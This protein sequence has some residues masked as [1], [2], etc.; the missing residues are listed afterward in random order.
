MSRSPEGYGRGA[1]GLIHLATKGVEKT[2]NDLSLSHD[3][4][5]TSMQYHTSTAVANIEG[6]QQQKVSLP[7]YLVNR[8]CFYHF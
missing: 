6:N 2:T 3:Q 5:Q 4:H 7:E 1:S 8:P